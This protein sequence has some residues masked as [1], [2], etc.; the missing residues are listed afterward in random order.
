MAVE[1]AISPSPSHEASPSLKRATRS[2]QRSK[3]SITESLR[4]NWLRS[5]KGK[6]SAG[7]PAAS[8]SILHQRSK[9]KQAR[10]KFN[11]KI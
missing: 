3:A 9:K 11:E 4:A 2:S 8:L 10:D 7:M 6:V 5:G 1:K